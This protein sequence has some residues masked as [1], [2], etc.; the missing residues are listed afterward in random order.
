MH[1]L[2]DKGEFARLA[3]TH[4]IPCPLSVPVTTRRELLEFPLAGGGDY[5]FKPFDSQSFRRRYGVKAMS[6]ADREGALS[7]WDEH[8]LGSAGVLIQEYVPGRADDHYF[9]D[10]FIDRRGDVITNLARRRTR[11]Y[12]TDFGNS[13]LC[14]SV[15]MDAVGPAWKALDALLRSVSYRGIFS[16]EFK[17]DTRDG[18]FRLLEINTRPWVYIQF[19][20]ECG[21]NF[22]DLYIR[23]ALG[24]ALA[25]QQP[26]DTYK[27]CANLVADF[28]ALRSTPAALRPGSLGIFAIWLSSFKLVFDWTD[29]RPAMRSVVETLGPWIARFRRWLSDRRGRPPAIRGLPD[30]GRKPKASQ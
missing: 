20:N 9:I 26:T 21:V 12:P 7:L 10:G 13:S 18:R 3:R 11:M 29:L 17:R 6:F 19:A 5:F 4:D 1:L 8:D 15:S 25:V 14:E 2:Q 16:A 23:D 28:R 27:T 24:E 22:C 30:G